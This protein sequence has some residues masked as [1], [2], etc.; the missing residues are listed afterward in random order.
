MLSTAKRQASEFSIRT[1]DAMHVKQISEAGAR[2]YGHRQGGVCAGACAALLIAMATRCALARATT[3][4]ANDPFP[5]ATPQAVVDVSRR[6]FPAVVRLDVA[7]ETYAEGKRT[8]KRGIG[9]G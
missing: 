9:S 1:Q 3:E 6:I 5:S 2:K 8:V 4:E 7:Q